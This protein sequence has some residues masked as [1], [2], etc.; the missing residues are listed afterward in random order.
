MIAGIEI[1][2]DYEYI[3]NCLPICNELSET[4]AKK[5]IINHVM[6]KLQI[7]VEMQFKIKAKVFESSSFTGYKVRLL[8]VFKNKKERISGL[9]IIPPGGQLPSKYLIGTLFPHET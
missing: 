3:E 6:S 9:Y 1:T 5:V 7:P 8:Q 4:T 2:I